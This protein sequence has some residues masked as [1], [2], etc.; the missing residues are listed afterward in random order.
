MVL[1]AWQ[2]AAGQPSGV[3]SGVVDQSKPRSRSPI[4]PPA[5]N[6]AVSSGG[7]DDSPAA[8]DDQPASPPPWAEPM[9]PPAPAS[10][11][12]RP[13]PLRRPSLATTP[14]VE[15]RNAFGAMDAGYLR[16]ILS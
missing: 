13:A 7:S 15:Q 12:R 2:S 9:Q 3:P 10:Y 11:P 4:S 5:A 8:G 6:A 16:L 1:T 14:T